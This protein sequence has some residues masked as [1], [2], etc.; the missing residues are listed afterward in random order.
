MIC[1]H[2]ANAAAGGKAVEAH[3]PARA[4]SPRTHRDA[5]RHHHHTHGAGS[6]HPGGHHL[7]AVEHLSVAFSMYDPAA[8]FFRARRVE[9]RVIDDLSLSVH[10]GEI[11]AVVGASGSGKTLLAD[12]ILGTY[13][14][15]AQVTGS[16]WFDGQLQDDLVAA[17]G[18]ERD[19]GYR[20][21]LH[22]LHQHG[23]SRLHAADL[24]IGGI[25]DRIA[26]EDIESL[27]EPDSRPGGQDHRH[28]EY[29]DLNLSFHNKL[30]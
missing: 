20:T 23:R 9:N 1:A 18:V 2:T 19:S 24:V 3:P 12:A 25:I 22:A 7:L 5:E 13:E 30:F 14:P 21:D 15:N 17:P 26:A 27:Q 4:A 11:L 8:P 29:S 6:R 10:Q 16:I 28:G